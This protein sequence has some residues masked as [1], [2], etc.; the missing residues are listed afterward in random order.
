MARPNTT[1]GNGFKPNGVLN[2]PLGWRGGFITLT[3]TGGP[4]DAFE[5]FD[6]AADRAYGVMVRAE[7][8]QGYKKHLHLP[9]HDFQVPDDDV[10]THTAVRRA[11]LAA[12]RGQEVFVGCMGG[13][14]RTGLFLA[15]MAKAVGIPEPVRYVRQHY[16]PRA[17]ETDEQQAYVDNFDVSGIAGP[18]RRTA[19]LKRL[20][21]A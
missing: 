3:I 11:L 18:V 4:Y 16:T 17:I 19:W 14:G 2:L 6:R 13:W 10:R 9:I 12:V 21:L 7:R 1:I 8:S 15:L 20:G 5:E